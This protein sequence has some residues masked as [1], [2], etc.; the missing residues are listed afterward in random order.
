VNDPPQ[1]W[2]RD[3]AVADD[4]RIDAVRAVAATTG[5]TPSGPA[6]HDDRVDAVRT[7][8]GADWG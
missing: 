8:A 7:V 5:S 3:R 1:L 6:P 4:D 2:S